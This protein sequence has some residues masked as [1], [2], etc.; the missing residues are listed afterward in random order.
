MQEIG[1]F[2]V[3]G[4][5]LLQVNII[6]RIIAACSKGKDKKKRRKRGV[7]RYRGEDGTIMVL[8]PIDTT[9][10]KIYIKNPVLD[11]SF[12]MQFQKNFR[13]PYDRFLWMVDD[14]NED[15]CY[16]RW[17]GSKTTPMSLLILGTL[18]YLG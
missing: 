9:W 6:I 8:K 15:D 4:V 13:V 11:D 5:R 17:H 14:S 10:Y 1:A 7:L 2:I 3:R 16:S 12:K 18:R